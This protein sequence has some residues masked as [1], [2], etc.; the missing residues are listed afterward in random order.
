MKT[1]GNKAVL[2]AG[3]LGSIKLLAESFGYSVISDDQINDIAN[4]ASALLA[5]IAAFTNNLK[6]KTN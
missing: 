5:V 3:V 6:P 2:I 4:G 1:T